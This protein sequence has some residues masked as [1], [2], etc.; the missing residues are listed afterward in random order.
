MSFLSLAFVLIYLLNMNDM[1]I[2]FATN[3]VKNCLCLT[4]NVN[5]IPSIDAEYCLE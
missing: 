1:R 2:L 4:C 3:T 5:R